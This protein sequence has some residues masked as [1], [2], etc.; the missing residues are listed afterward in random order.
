LKESWTKN[1]SPWA[2][3]KNERQYPIRCHREEAF[4]VEIYKYLPAKQRGDPEKNLLQKAAKKKGLAASL[5]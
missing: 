3:A 2:D 1:F 4:A 5:V